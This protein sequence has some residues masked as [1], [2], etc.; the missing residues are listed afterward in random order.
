MKLPGTVQLQFYI[1]PA[2][3]TDHMRLTMTERFRPKGLLGI[4]YWYSVGPLHNL[5][6]GGMMNGIKRAAEASDPT[7]PIG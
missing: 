7:Q 1:D 4:L 6:F 2:A 5:V 3:E